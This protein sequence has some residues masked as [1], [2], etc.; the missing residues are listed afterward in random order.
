MRTDNV[1]DLTFS[2]SETSS[3]RRTQLTPPARPVC[4][5]GTYF[6]DMPRIFQAQ[7]FIIIIYLHFKGT[8]RQVKD[9]EHVTKT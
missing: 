8:C 3:R 1:S 2:A 4:M 6:L 7:F 5:I 9:V